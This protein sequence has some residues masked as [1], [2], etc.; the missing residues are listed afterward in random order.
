MKLPQEDADLFFKLMW[1]V[2]FFINQKLGIFPE[3]EDVESYQKRSTEDKMKVRDALYKNLHLLKDFIEENPGNL[4]EQ[5]LG[6]VASWKHC[7]VGDFYM[8]RFLKAYTVMIDDDNNVY[9]VQGLNQSLDEIIHK[10]Y[11]PMRVKTVLLPF[12]DKIIYDGLLQHYNI[13]FGGNITAEL[14]DTYLAAKQNGSIITNLEF[15]TSPAASKKAPSVMKSWDKELEELTALAAKLRGGAGQPPLL[16]PAFS[17]IRASLE[18]ATL[19][20]ATPA[21][22]DK[23]FKGLGK[24]ERSVRQAENVLMRMSD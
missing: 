8:E 12:K 24:L 1:H 13:Y 2:Q 19:A 7:R 23:L 22:M 21:D 3:I 9:G 11:L 10:S 14:K 16:S 15:K 20:T 18:F 17:L 5:E 6:I 4:T